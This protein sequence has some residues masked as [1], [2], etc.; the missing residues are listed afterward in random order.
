MND[1]GAAVINVF[2]FPVRC[3]RGESRARQRVCAVQEDAGAVP[4]WSIFAPCGALHLVS[5]LGCAALI[6]IVVRAGRSAGSKDAERAVRRSIALF[7]LA[8]WFVD[9]IAWNWHGIDVSEGLPLQLCDVAGV[10]APLALLTLDRR[11]RAAVYFWGLTLTTQAFIQPTLT[12][13]PANLLFW[14]FWISHTVILGCAVYD[15]VV[16]G[17]RPGWA[18][19]GRALAVSAAYLA[20]VVPVNLLLASDY[21]YIGNP[22]PGRLIPPFVALLGPWPQR[23]FVVVALAAMAFLLALAPW[24]VRPRAPRGTPSSAGAS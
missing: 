12:Q 5:A 18:D 17:F 8:E 14:C 7:G 13:G 1:R 19:L 6:T 3:R 20:V 10:V 2:E 16:L 22:P 15:L 23:A 11:L 4:D 21:G 24:V 9:N